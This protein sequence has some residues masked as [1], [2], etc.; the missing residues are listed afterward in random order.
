MKY[1]V[2]VL[3][4]IAVKLAVAEVA[5]GQVLDPVARARMTLQGAK[6]AEAEARATIPAKAKRDV[7]DGMAGA[8]RLMQEQKVPVV[9]GVREGVVR[10]AGAVLRQVTMAEAAKAAMQACKAGKC[11]PQPGQGVQVLAAEA[12]SGAAAATH[13]ICPSCGGSGTSMAAMGREGLGV[14]TRT[15]MVSSTGRA[16]SIVDRVGAQLTGAERGA[17]ERLSLD[18]AQ[19]A[20]RSMSMSRSALQTIIDQAK[21]KVSQ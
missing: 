5:H 6:D 3:L 15:E 2:R 20:G 13:V 16:S 11:T 7:F 21:A 19:G 10:V 12:P 18:A 9:L 17:A 8:A 1:H 14:V 4:C